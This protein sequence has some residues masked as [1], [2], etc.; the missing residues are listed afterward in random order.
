MHDRVRLDVAEQVGDVMPL[1][2]FARD[3]ADVG[4]LFLQ[5]AERR[6]DH[7]VEANHV[8][9]AGSK[10]LDDRGADESVGPRDDDACHVAP[11]IRSAA[12]CAPWCQVYRLGLL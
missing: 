1:G 3:N 12:A 9:A 6:A 11:F 7:D 8:V 10:C 4:A 2:D 5:R